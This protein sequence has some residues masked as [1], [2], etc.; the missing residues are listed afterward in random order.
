MPL[1]QSATDLDQLPDL[2]HALAE[3]PA[4]ELTLHYFTSDP[5]Y[6]LSGSRRAQPGDIALCGAVKKSP[7]REELWRLAPSCPNCARLLA[8]R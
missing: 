1:S 5:R 7:H 3:D 8:L 4:S 6:R 2:D